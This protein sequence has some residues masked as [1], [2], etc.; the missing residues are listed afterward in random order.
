ML[1]IRTMV[2]SGSADVRICGCRNKDRAMVRDRVKIKVR[3]RLRAVW[4][5]SIVLCKGIVRPVIREYGMKYLCG[6]L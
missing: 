2:K 3:I 1:T 4:Y 5:C 6:P